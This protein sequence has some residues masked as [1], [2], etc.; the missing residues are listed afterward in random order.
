MMQ[1]RFGALPEWA[2]QRLSQAS[3]QQLSALAARLFESRTL[4]ELFG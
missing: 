1:Q 3:E 2:T 4:E